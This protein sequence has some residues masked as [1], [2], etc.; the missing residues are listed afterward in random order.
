MCSPV[1]VHFSGL[2]AS[3]SAS[4]RN[5]SFSS[6]GAIMPS[7]SGTSA[8]HMDDK[9]IATARTAGHAF[10]KLLAVTSGWRRHDMLWTATVQ[11]CTPSSGSLSWAHSSST[12]SSS[13]GCEICVWCTKAD[14]D[15]GTAYVSRNIGAV[16]ECDPETTGSS[17]ALLALE[18][19]SGLGC[20]VRG[21]WC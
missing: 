3:P 21:T 11:R 12:T 16:R 9:P 17:G 5:S 4:S 8:S 13:S 20:S 7:G 18:Y 10:L 14:M 6:V 15:Q 2:L 1:S 19:R